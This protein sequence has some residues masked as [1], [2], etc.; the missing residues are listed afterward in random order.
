MTL[1]PAARAALKWYA[2]DG[3][4]GTEPTYP[5]IRAL[6]AAKLLSPAGVITD[7]GR[8]EAK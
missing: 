1:T 6:I 8:E 2:T 5:V 4:E 7:K 3:E